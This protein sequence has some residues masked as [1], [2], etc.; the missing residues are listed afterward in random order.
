MSDK[1]APVK[2]TSPDGT[3]TTVTLERSA[4]GLW[5][6]SVKAD[7]TGLYRL[8]SGK[9]SAVTHVG[10]LNSRELSAVTATAEKLQPVLT[11]SGGG[12]FWTGT[13]GRTDEVQE[14]ELPRLISLPAARKMYGAGWL[15]LARRDAYIVRG[16]QL[17][18]LFNGF[19]ALALALGLLSL[20]WF[21]EGR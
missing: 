19:L 17:T 8:T 7:N 16:V 9:L 10:L 15:G 14:L 11:Q 5:R 6:K 20:T 2:V 4:P 18:P 13:A 1:V 3:T 21:R 12:A